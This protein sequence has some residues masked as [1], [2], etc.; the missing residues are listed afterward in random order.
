M[1]RSRKHQNPE[2]FEEQAPSPQKKLAP[3]RARNEAQQTL[4]QHLSSRQLTF[5]LG[6]AG[7]GKTYGATRFACELLEDRE[8]E[9]ILITRPM[10]SAEEDIGFLPGKVEDKFAP[11][12]APIREIMNDHLGTSH[13]QNLIK[14]RKIE[15][16]PIGFLRGHTFKN[17]F[18]LFDEA[19]NTTPN[20]MRLFLSRIGDNSHVCVDG[21]LAQCDIQGDSG[22]KDAIRRFEKLPEVG[23]A[24]FTTDDIVRSGLAKKILE[25]YK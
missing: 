12:F 17:C 15:I 18:V 16:A 8:I 6:P 14:N 11:Y 9:K 3:L 13:V 10:V 2:F 21:D 1:A 5:A 4:L 7:T 23:V 19:Q 25:G 24:R 20:Q 22:L